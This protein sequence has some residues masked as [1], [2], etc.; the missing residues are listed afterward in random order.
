MNPQAVL[1]ERNG[2]LAAIENQFESRDCAQT[3][4]HILL[5]HLALCCSLPSLRDEQLQLHAY[6]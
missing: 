1:R 5:S 3:H 4:L 2:S 6:A